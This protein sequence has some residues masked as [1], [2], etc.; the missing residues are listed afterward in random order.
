MS[1]K[2]GPLFA[3]ATAAARSRTHA[4]SSRGRDAREQAATSELASHAQPARGV[5]SV[6]LSEIQIGPTAFGIK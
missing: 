6:V 3:A 1:T 5:G 2:L 4:R